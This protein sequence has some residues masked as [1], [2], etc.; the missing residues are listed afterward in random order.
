MRQ[1]IGSTERYPNSPSFENINTE[2]LASDIELLDPRHFSDIPL[3]V[4]QLIGT[5]CDLC[6][7]SVLL[8]G[9][10]KDENESA[11]CPNC[12]TPVLQVF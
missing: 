1:Q 4:E 11:F 10:Y 5:S 6:D 2:E 3:P 7:E 12:D 9:K 8:Y